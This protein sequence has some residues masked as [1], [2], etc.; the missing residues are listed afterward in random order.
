M[1]DRADLLSNDS[2]FGGR[3]LCRQFRQGYRFSVDA[4]L[5]AHFLGPRPQDA[6]LDL[7]CGSGIISLILAYRH[8][9]IRVT[10]LEVQTELAHLAGKNVIDNDLGG[11]VKIIHGNLRQIEEFMTAE[12]FDGVVCNPPYR[13]PGKG[14]VSLNE[15]RAR[16]RHE[17]DAGLDDIVR[18]ASF[19]V[20]N[21][22][23]VVVVYPAR[24]AMTLIAALK[25][26][27]LEPK[28]LQPVYS[29]PGS[30]EAALV[31]VEAVKNGG[32]EVRIQAP[33]YIYREQ[34]GSFSDV[35]LNLYR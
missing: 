20:K 14:R 31:L 32:E 27:R 29:Y 28:R 8:P 12:S 34:N 26:R 5:A 9:E 19:S 23:S 18:A 2:L 25:S 35:M 7:G 16:A 13:E 4:V 24:R 10:G 6:I 33:L 22:G 1:K 11:R 3:L 17:I 30:A 15:Q 21:R